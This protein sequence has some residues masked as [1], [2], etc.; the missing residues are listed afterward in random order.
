[1]LCGITDINPHNRLV[2]KTEMPHLGSALLGLTDPRI[3]EERYRRVSGINA[4]KAS[5]N[6]E[7]GSVACN[8]VWGLPPTATPRN[9]Y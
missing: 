4:T 1:M 2:A 7:A 8:P 6:G 3:T 5:I 9:D